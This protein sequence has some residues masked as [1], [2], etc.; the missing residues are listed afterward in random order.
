MKTIIAIFKIGGAGLMLPF[1][2]LF[3][4]VCFILKDKKETGQTIIVVSALAGIT[5]KLENIF[6]SKGL[7]V[8]PAPT[9]FHAQSPLMPH[10]FIPSAGALKDSHYAMHEWLGL[11]WY[12]L[13]HGSTW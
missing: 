10:D 4:L 1:Q 6:Q 13:R 11:L 2:E 8:T 5:R 7:T 9:G 12:R 3:D